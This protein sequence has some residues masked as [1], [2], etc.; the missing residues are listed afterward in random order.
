MIKYD[1]P[2]HDL[3]AVAKV[4]DG[5]FSSAEAMR[6]MAS[7]STQSIFTKSAKTLTKNELLEKLDDDKFIITKKGK[8]HLY[9]MVAERTGRQI[10]FANSID[11]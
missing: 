8:I 2:S 11:W 3:L 1:S 4:L 9:A 10:G 6:V 5:E 7:L